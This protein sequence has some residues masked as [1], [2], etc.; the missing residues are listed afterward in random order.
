MKALIHAARIMRDELLL[1]DRLRNP[2]DSPAANL[3]KGRG[4]LANLKILFM[5]NVTKLLCGTP[6]AADF[7]CFSG[8]RHATKAGSQRRPVVVWHITRRCNLRCGHCY[9]DSSAKQYPGELSLQQCIDVI[10]D[11][12]DYQVPA[13]VLSGGEPMLH[14][15]FF[16]LAG[17]AVA[18]GLRIM[19]STNGTRIDLHS[20]QRLKDLGVAYVGISLTGVG[21]SHDKFRGRD[22]AF[23]KAMEAFRHCR[24]AGQRAGLRITLDRQTA[25]Q[26]P[27]VLR[28]IEEEDIPRVCFRHLVYGGRGEN[29]GPLPA[30]EARSALRM[31]ADATVRWNREGHA[32]EV[33]TMDQPADG[34]FFWLTMLRKNPERA[35]AIWSVLSGNDNLSSGLGISNIDSQGNVHPDQYWQE[36]TLGNVKERAFSRIWS[37]TQD[38]LLSGLRDCLPRLQGRC[39]ECR[40]KEVCGGGF[41]VRAFQKFGDPWAEDPGC[42]LR[43]HEIEPAGLPA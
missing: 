29:P 42:Y 33:L 27:E 30:S 6:E 18:R 34:A 12:A 43:D 32:R 14:P 38:E 16:D 9:S 21:E 39:A 10:D 41:R 3:P 2:F 22:G 4:C 31:I 11:L 8:G 24:G 13:L 1:E 35:K 19:V 23:E 17:Y 25:G 15:H 7:L 37:S 20:A 28:L 26:L 40:F 5:I 36:H